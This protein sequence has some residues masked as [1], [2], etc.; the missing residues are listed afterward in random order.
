MLSIRVIF[1]LGEM[2]DLVFQVLSTLRK[3]P[4]NLLTH[5]SI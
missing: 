4:V 1:R 2:S 5:L 3:I